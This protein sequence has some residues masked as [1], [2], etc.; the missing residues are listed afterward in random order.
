MSDYFKA[1]EV[2]KNRSNGGKK[3]ASEIY[4]DRIISML[5]RLSFSVAFRT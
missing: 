4:S 2:I 3:D 1:Y 5:M